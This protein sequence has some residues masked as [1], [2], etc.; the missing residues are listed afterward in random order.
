M[1]YVGAKHDFHFFGKL[2]CF[3][4]LNM[5]INSH[6]GCFNVFIVYNF[7]TLSD[8]TFTFCCTLNK[9]YTFSAKYSAIIIMRIKWIIHYTLSSSDLTISVLINTTH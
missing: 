5:N 4:N 1:T 7:A 6:T 9:Q 3:D 2:T 8:L